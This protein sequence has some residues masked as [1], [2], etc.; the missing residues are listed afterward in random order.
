M[1]CYRQGALYRN[2]V[3]RIW[4]SR[5]KAQVR[6]ADFSLM[7]IASGLRTNRARHGAFNGGWNSLWALDPHRFGPAA[8]LRNTVAG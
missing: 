7:W 6:D 5:Q 4:L 2:V 1:Q 8:Q 3:S